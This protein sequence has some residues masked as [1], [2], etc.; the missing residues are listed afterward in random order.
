MKLS[1]RMKRERPEL[2]TQFDLDGPPVPEDIKSTTTYMTI[3]ELAKHYD[4]SLVVVRKWLEEKGLAPCARTASWRKAME[5]EE[6]KE[7]VRPRRIPEDDGRTFSQDVEL[8][9]PIAANF[10]RKKFG[11]V[12][13]ADIRM[14][15]GHS[16]TWGAQYNCP[17]G[18]RK[19]YF[20]SGVGVLWLDE[21]LELAEK[22][23][24]ARKQP[25][26]EGAT[27]NVDV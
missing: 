17:K 21:F 7:P 5:R 27:P 11:N 19:Q 26:T 24:Y 14:R 15:E 10:L 22:H 18:G 4:V 1:K 3:T 16:V 8:E 6:T 20:V 23:G 13:R 9:A 2:H 25:V 12:F